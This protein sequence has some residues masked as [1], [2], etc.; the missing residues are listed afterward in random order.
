MGMDLLMTNQI[1]SNVSRISAIILTALLSLA[2]LA[3]AQSTLADGSTSTAEFIP[4]YHNLVFNSGLTVNSGSENTLSFNYLSSLA[5]EKS[6]RNHWFSE[7]TLV[8]KAGAIACRVTKSVLIDD[9]LDHIAVVWA[10]EYFG[11][12]ARYR[13]L[14]IDD[15][16]YSI[17]APPP[18]GDGGGSASSSTEGESFTPHEVAAIYIGGFEVQSAIDRLISMRW[19]ANKTIR[20]RESSLYFRSFQIMY[21]YIMGLKDD[22]PDKNAARTRQST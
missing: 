19:V 16:T 21:D 1:T 13:E 9:P 17:D 20:Y 11:H 8:A 22:L 5:M 10:H 4:E 14:E 15:V 2:S 12:G 7:K 18:Y 6:I 3:G